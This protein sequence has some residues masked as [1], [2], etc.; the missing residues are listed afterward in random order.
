MCRLS[1]VYASYVRPVWHI[2]A[3]LADLMISLGLVKSALD[4]Y[5]SIER[6]ESVIMCYTILE[7]KHKVSK[8]LK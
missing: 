7:L 4:L 5:L 8:R 6:W 1:H 2:Q 3:Q